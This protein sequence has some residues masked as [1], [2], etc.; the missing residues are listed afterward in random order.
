M[1]RRTHPLHFRKKKARTYKVKCGDYWAVVKVSVDSYAHGGYLWNVGA[2]VHRSQRA[3]NDWYNEYRNKRV[4]SVENKNKK[5]P[6]ACLF[7]M[8]G[9]MRKAIEETDERDHLY[10][11]T[12][13]IEAIGWDYVTRLGFTYVP[14]LKGSSFRH[15]WVLTARSM[16]EG[17]VLVVRNISDTD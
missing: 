13:D 15:Y 3:I 8:V 5:Y 2:A 10:I 6:A 9:L 4:R 11:M 17:K 14:Y 16:G 1:P 12:E 7:K